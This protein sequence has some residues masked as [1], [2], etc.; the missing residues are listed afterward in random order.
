M[1]TLF[2]KE[3]SLTAG[4]SSRFA[5]IAATKFNVGFFSY[6]LPEAEERGQNFF[7]SLAVEGEP[8][9]NLT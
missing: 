1:I 9:L 8:A 5:K 4:F 7:Y 6:R 2:Q 3:H